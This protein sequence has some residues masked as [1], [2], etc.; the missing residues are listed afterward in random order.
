MIHFDVS[1]FFFYVANVNVR[2][3]LLQ[4]AQA[5]NIPQNNVRNAV[6]DVSNTYLKLITY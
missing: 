4:M 2:V 6:I 5:M 3:F 1:F